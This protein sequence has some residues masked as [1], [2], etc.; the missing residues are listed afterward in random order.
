MI[1]FTAIAVL[2]LLA[3]LPATAQVNPYPPA[4]STTP[5]SSN[6]DGPNSQA[7][8]QPVTTI[9]QPPVVLPPELAGMPRPIDWDQAYKQACHDVGFQRTPNVS[10]LTRE[11]YC[12]CV[13]TNMENGKIWGPVSEYDLARGMNIFRGRL[14]ERRPTAEE[15][16]S[17]KAVFNPRNIQNEKFA[18][19]MAEFSVTS[20]A[21]MANHPDIF[22]CMGT[23]DVQ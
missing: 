3:A 1:R 12:N 2:T 4:D 18:Q 5:S 15:I 10:M 19:S 14:A 6:A 16:N 11:R 13:F 21:L 20:V 9:K 23:G 22:L 7:R 17:K 8:T